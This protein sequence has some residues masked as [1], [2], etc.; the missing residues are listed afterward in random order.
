MKMNPQS[1]DNMTRMNPYKLFF[2][3]CFLPLAIFAQRYGQNNDSLYLI[4]KT[5]FLGYVNFAGKSVIPPQYKFAT[6]FSNGLALVQR[7][8]QYYYINR[9][10]DKITDIFQY[11]RLCPDSLLRP[12]KHGDLWGYLDQNYQ[13][14][15]PY[16][17][18]EA[19]DFYE[20]VAV[21]KKNGKWGYINRTGRM[22]L[23]TNYV[24]V[25]HFHEELAAVLV[26]VNDSS[27]KWGFIDK[28]GEMVI[29]PTF[30]YVGDF[31]FGR[32]FVYENEK[33]GFIDKTGKIRIPFQYSKA[34]NFKN[35]G[36]AKVQEK[37]KY[38]WIDTLGQKAIN[39]DLE[40]TNMTHFKNGFA[41]VM[42]GEKWGAINR[43]GEVKVPVIY[44]MLSDFEPFGLAIVKTGT[45][46]GLIDTNGKYALTPNYEL[47]EYFKNG[48]FPIKK[49]GKVGFANKMGRVKIIPTWTATIGFTSDGFAIV[50]KEKEL[51][52]IDS[53]GNPVAKMVAWRDFWK[54]GEEEDKKKK[55]KN[56]LPNEIWY[57]T[58]FRGISAFSDGYALIGV[59]KAGFIDNTG[60]MVVP[61]VFDEAQ[62]FSEGFAPVRVGHFW[63]FIGMNGEMAIQPQY[64]YAQPFRDGKAKVYT[65][66]THF[67]Y[68]R[69][70]GTTINEPNVKIEAANENDEFY[71]TGKLYDGLMLFKD[72]KLEKYGYKNPEGKVIIQADFD[73]ACDFSGGRALVEINNHWYYIDTEGGV[74]WRE[75]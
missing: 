56:E 52:K 69:K 36:W 61:P 42:I 49:N 51:F 20:E 57:E 16:Q 74:V 68:I 14:K 7:N 67:Y 58:D 62:S 55:K 47:I 8:G 41:R 45:Q 73:N 1:L 46:F 63:G 71:K 6:P 11:T 31:H 23:E 12:I 13:S 21:V 15:I 30:S 22:Y 9:N 18:E 39:V 5:G 4:R 10:N 29:K 70:D 28:S 75:E 65:D 33:Y 60:T 64:A 25:R 3:F 54:A 40:I 35:E 66:L 27:E 53:L 34:D 48:F 19:N 72:K 24:E 2:L 37:G 32:A 59:G 44:D 43:K 26:H 17:F 50:A 38:L